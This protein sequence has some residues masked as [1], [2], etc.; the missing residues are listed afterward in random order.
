MKQDAPNSSLSHG[1]VFI[2]LIAMASFVA[3]DD[4]VWVRIHHDASHPAVQAAARLAP[5]RDYDGFQWGSM[6]ESMVRNLERDNIRI[7]IIPNPFELALGGE[8]FDPAERSERGLAYQAEPEGDWHLIQFDG[9][10]RAEWMQALTRSGVHVVQPLHPFSFLVWADSSRINAARALSQVRFAGAMQPEWK[11]QPGRSVSRSLNTRTMALISAH[12]DLADIRYRLEQF[13]EVHTLAPYNRHFRIVYMDV[14]PDHYQHISEIPAVY[15]IQQIPPEAGPRGEMSNQ[16]IAGGID[17]GGNI[18]PGY[19]NWLATAGFDGS[20]IL[21]G[22]VDGGIRE[23]H[24]DLVGS[25]APCVASG[26]FPTSC[27]TANSNHGSHVAGAIAGTAASGATDSAGFLRGQGTAPGAQVIQQRYASFLDSSDTENGFMVPDGMLKIFRESALSGALLANNSW[28]PTGSPQGYDIPT[29]QIDFIT[30]DADP[31]TPGHQPILPI[32]AIMN[33]N[34][35]SGG[36]CA[37]S[38]LGSPDEAKNHFAVGS[39][40]LQTTGGAQVQNIFRI[41]NNSAHGPACDGRR[42]PHI[43]APGCRTDSICAGGI[44]TCTS[45]SAY[46]LACGTSMAAPVVSGAIAVWAEKYLAEHGV[47]PSPA[48]AKSVFTAAAHNLVGN[49]NADGVTM[50]HRPDRFQ[51]Y[52]RIDL[53]FVMYPGLEVF[54]FDQAHVFSQSG[55][56]WQLELAADNANEPMRIMLAWTD[57]PG[58]G[59]GG[60]TP[61]WVNNLDLLVEA[62]GENY[63]GNVIGDDGWSNPGGVADDRNNLEAVYLS[64]TQHGGNITLKVLASDIAGDALDPWNPLMTSQDFALACYNC[65]PAESTFTLDVQPDRLEACIP[66]TDPIQLETTVE[67]GTI[68][69]PDDPV[70]LTSGGEP[71]GVT[72]AINPVSVSAPAQAIWSL[73]VGPSAQAGQS[74]ATLTADDTTR[75]LQRSLLLTLHARPDVPGL[76]EPQDGA[77]NVDLLPL[78]VWQPVEDTLEYRVQI[79]SDADFTQLVADEALATGTFL[80]DAP[81]E[82]DTE[83]YWRVQGIN[84]CG[85]GQWSEIA[86]F[87]TQAD[88]IIALSTDSMQ[89]TLHEGGSDSKM[90]EI[91]NLGTDPLEW[92]VMTDEPGGA[93]GSGMLSDCADSLPQPAWIETSPIQG[94]VDAGDNETV[95]VLFDAGDLVPGEYLTHICFESNDVE[96]PVVSLEVTLSV[97]KLFSDRFE[98]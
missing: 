33:G 7:T 56:D 68:G 71:G 45:D 59:L 41:S 34:G 76:Q 16:S 23:S 64:P 92:M 21:V 73:T 50:D 40:S 74:T 75:A 4:T 46:G 18:F 69:N 3:A 26:D 42:V 93:E 44:G 79:A 52:G 14:A 11:Q 88:A 77:E 89:L 1:L 60:E 31:F 30:R 86:A 39:T 67:I 84:D 61:A 15:T 80:P 72:S 98:E 90:I 55:Q 85:S 57:A 48:L 91:G 94:V 53:D 62:E 9:P 58:H 47:Y 12:A 38:S 65:V 10:I 27:T 54:T 87:T 81:L 8:R 36:A 78:F 17:G 25:T 95:A 63:L 2:A 20:G 28:G 43:V 70:Q 32:W 51:G 6:P 5:L 35:D 24:Q 97:S 49:P 29:Q 37:P 13:G 19:G 96:T 66:P 82:T 83:H 22:V